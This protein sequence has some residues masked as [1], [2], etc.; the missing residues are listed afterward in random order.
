MD[1]DSF[2][3][4]LLSFVWLQNPDLHC[5]SSS[6][7]VAFPFLVLKKIWVLA[8]FLSEWFVS[9]CLTNVQNTAR[10]HNN[11]EDWSETKYARNQTWFARLLQFV[12]LQSAFG[13][14]V[15][16]SPENKDFKLF[17]KNLSFSIIQWNKLTTTRVILAFGLQEWFAKRVALPLGLEL[18]CNDPH[19]CMI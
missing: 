8:S 3:P 12:V 18:I 16:R 17:I 7:F 9:V 15:G 4:L 5:F 10:T 1:L 11:N 19:I 2:L 6:L 14:E 13:V